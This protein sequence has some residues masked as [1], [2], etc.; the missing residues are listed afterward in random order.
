MAPNTDTYFQL[1]QSGPTVSGQWSV[2][3]PTVMNHQMDYHN[4]KP[5]Y[6][7]SCENLFKIIISNEHDL[8]DVMYSVIILRT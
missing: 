3:G 5:K 4:Q 7:I 8:N 2:R 6:N 1:N